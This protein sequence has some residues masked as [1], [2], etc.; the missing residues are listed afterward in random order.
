MTAGVGPGRERDRAAGREVLIVDDNED[1]ADVLH[2]VLVSNGYRVRVAHDGAEGLVM[3]GKALPDLIV[4]DV[5][6]PHLT[7]PELACRMFIHDAGME[8]V[9]IV[10]TSGRPSVRRGRGLRRNALLPGEALRARRDPRADPTRPH[11]AAPS[12]TGPLA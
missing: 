7:G 10:L 2:A 3:L 4:L 5:E 11:R 12:S 6:M 9:P 8:K 1:L